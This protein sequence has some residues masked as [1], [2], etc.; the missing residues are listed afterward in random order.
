MFSLAN[1]NL[2]LVMIYALLAF[3]DDKKSDWIKLFLV[4]VFSCYSFLLATFITFF[5][6]F[7]MIIYSFLNK[8]KK[9]MKKFIICFMLVFLCFIPWI[10]F[11]LEQIVN[12]TSDRYWQYFPY[13]FMKF[14]MDI[15]NI[16]ILGFSNGYCINGYVWASFM[17]L[18]IFIA[19][20]II[21]NFCNKN[22]NKKDN[23][24]FILFLVFIS[25][26]LFILLYSYV[27]KTFAARYF[28]ILYS[29]LLLS[30]IYYFVKN[31]N[32]FNISVFIVFIIMFIFNYTGVIN[33]G[34]L[35]G[36][37]DLEKMKMYLEKHS[38]IDE[39]NVFILHSFE[40]S[41]E[42]LGSSYLNDK[43]NL[44][45]Y[46]NSF[47]YDDNCGEDQ[48]NILNNYE[49]FGNNVYTL[50]DIE[51]IYNYTDHFYMIFTKELLS[52]AGSDVCILN[53]LGWDYKFIDS[54]VYGYNR[55]NYNLY[56]V[57]ISR[58]EE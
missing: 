4:S 34:N 55:V 13:S 10:P 37:N 52:K 17:V 29:I 32:F 22:L 45:F 16:Y 38:E 56:E 49:I 6:L 9:L 5:I 36:N 18:L 14:F 33:S 30:F 48:K 15:T 35:T 31:P 47:L 12:V 21:F 46:N 50:S 42:V 40:S 3:R 41:L 24:L 54:Y 51:D 53:N 27:N 25:S 44:I 8:E 43:V 2:F 19:L 26:F 58:N 28:T 7:V 11:L 23:I 39:D 57:N 20:S 1:L